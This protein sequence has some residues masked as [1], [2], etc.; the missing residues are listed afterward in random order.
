MRDE[1]QLSDLK[2]IS[3]TLSSL[4]AMKM[5][6]VIWDKYPSDIVQEIE[7]FRAKYGDLDLSD[8]LFYTYSF[9]NMLTGMAA[10]NATRAKWENDHPTWFVTHEVTLSIYP[11]MDANNVLNFYF[12]P[13]W[14]KQ[15]SF[16]AG[17]PMA[18]KIIDIVGAIRD[19]PDPVYPNRPYYP[20]Y[21]GYIYDLGSS[22]P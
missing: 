7:R 10:L 22:C 13:T 14:I 8:T 6:N 20:N 18:G 15:D 16:K 19:S 3:D 11:A 9:T 21:I 17:K 2:L 4:D 5:T 12:I 1:K